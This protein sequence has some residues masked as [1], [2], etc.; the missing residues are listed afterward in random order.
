VPTSSSHATPQRVALVCQ[1]LA[2][3]HRVAHPD[4]VVLQR[5]HPPAWTGLR[6][7]WIRAV[8]SFGLPARHGNLPCRA[9]TARHFPA[10]APRGGD[11]CHRTGLTPKCSVTAYLIQRALGP[12]INPE[13]RCA[14]HQHYRWGLALMP[15]SVSVRGRWCTD[16]K[17][18]Q[19]QTRFTPRRSRRLE[20]SASH[21]PV[22]LCASERAMYPSRRVYRAM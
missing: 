7:L 3:R 18:E 5:R 8:F 13:D 22:E 19:A 12:A 15:A 20:L 11:A 14:P 1:V 2:A 9:G 21:M 4:T 17:P 16:A 10:F 6:K